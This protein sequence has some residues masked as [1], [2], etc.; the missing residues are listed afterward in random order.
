VVE[1]LAIDYPDRFAPL[2]MH[3]NGDAFA[4]PWS[5][6]RLD[7]FYSLGSAVPTFMVDAMWSAQLADYRYYV[8]QQLAQ[9][10]DMTLELTGNPV[11]GSTWDVTARVCFEGG[12]SRPVR[13]YTAA[14]L[15]NPPGLPSYSTN[16][17]MQRV[18]ET[19]INIAGGDCQDV[20]SRI[21]FDSVSMA[22]SQNIV[23]IAWA[24]K[25]SASAPTT[26]YQAGIMR[27]PFPSGSQLTTIEVNPT[28]VSI[29]VGGEIE[30]TAVG[31][32]Q[33]GADYPLENPSWSLGPGNGGGT[34]DPSSGTSTTFTATTP[35]PRQIL[36]KEDGLT[37]GALVT[38]TA[39][40]E[41]TT[42]EIDPT[43]TTVDVD[44]QVAYSATGKD[45][46]GDDFPL[47]API[48]SISGD[49]EGTFDPATGTTTTFT[50]TYPGSATI[51]CAEGGVSA[52]AEIEIDG[53]APRL[54][55]LSIDPASAQ[56]RVDDDVEF[57]ATGTD[58]YGKAITLT[59]PSWRIEGDGDGVFDPMTGAAITTFTAT[60][61]GT[62]QIIC[63]DDSVEGTA[64]IEI[65]P[66]GLPAPRKA[67][68]RVTP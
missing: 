59:D 10:A 19:D 44:S 4:L 34:F 52:T 56:I 63:T 18:F 3:V 33:S 66:S 24:Q 58:Q 43:E 65:T 5:Q 8:E 38:I 1:Q 2:S 49:G 55:E 40:P 61:E 20:T 16:I 46:Y 29:P 25:P 12:G 9:P 31:K 39:A 42:I 60:T 32:D 50:A 28:D 62:A 48:W 27:W 53:D 13:I 30:F 51:S 57:T 26:V 45:Q 35:G 64:T 7:V 11:G 67:G 15:D 21:T 54:A 22:S 47:D 14:T 36:C 37:G 17:L 41:L 68:R 6:H 23:I